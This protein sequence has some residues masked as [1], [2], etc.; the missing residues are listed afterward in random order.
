MVTHSRLVQQHFH[1]DLLSDDP[2]GR[3]SDGTESDSGMH[4]VWILTFEA[5]NIAFTS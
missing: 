5:S 4:L 1:V 3:S 2:V